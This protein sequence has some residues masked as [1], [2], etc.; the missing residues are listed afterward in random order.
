MSWEAVYRLRSDGTVEPDKVVDSHGETICEGFFWH[1]NAEKNIRLVELA[2]KMKETLHAVFA[3]LNGPSYPDQKEKL[4]NK[5]HEL[6][7][8]FNTERHSHSSG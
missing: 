8:E 4:K 2:P 7:K 6:L 3:S 1:Q 5:I